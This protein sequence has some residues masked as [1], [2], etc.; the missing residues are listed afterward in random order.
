M[1][2]HDYGYIW[3]EED[4]P[5]WHMTGNAARF[6]VNRAGFSAA[7]RR[8]RMTGETDSL[9]VSVIGAHARVRVVASD[10]GEPI[11]AVFEA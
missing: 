1:V 9:I 6:C 3:I 7:G 4:G 2:R 10:A 11:A 8:S 5:P